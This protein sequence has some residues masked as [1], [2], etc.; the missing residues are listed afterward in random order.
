MNLFL[1]Q[2]LCSA[3][4]LN[5]EHQPTVLHAT[6]EYRPEF[7][8]YV[9]TLNSLSLARLWNDIPTPAAHRDRLSTHMPYQ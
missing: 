7:Q 9:T 3:A 4:R 5:Q 6:I 1:G 8:P 2:I